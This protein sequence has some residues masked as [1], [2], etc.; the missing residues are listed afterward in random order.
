MANELKLI[1]DPSTQAGLTMTAIVRDQ[2]CTQ[3][4]ATVNMSEVGTACY[5][6]DY[7]V[8]SL[9][10]GQYSVEFLADSRL[11]G[12]GVL[13]IFDGE[14]TD[15]GGVCGA[16]IKQVNDINVKGVGTRSDPWNPA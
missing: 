1:L 4:G 2:T 6:G 7:D 10:D 14:E 15:I 11:V 5:L 8:S 16:N 13:N 3:Q 9:V 12:E